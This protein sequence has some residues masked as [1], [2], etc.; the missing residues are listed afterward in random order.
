MPYYYKELIYKKESLF[1]SLGRN[2]YIR[3]KGIAINTCGGEIQIN[4]ITSKYRIARCNICIPKEDLQQ[5]INE[6]QK[7]V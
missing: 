5:F 3:T 2:G 4:P 7:L 1:G 6:L